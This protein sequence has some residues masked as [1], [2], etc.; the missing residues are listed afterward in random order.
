MGV[1]ISDPIVEVDHLSLAYPTR[2]GHP[3]VPILQ[4]VSVA[5][6]RGGALTLMG[7]SGSGKS[8]LLRC[9]NRLVEPTAGTVRFDGR[10]I[11]SLDPR[12]LRRR[13]ALVMQTPVLFEGTVRD[14]L[15]LRPA[16]TPG[17]FA[18]ARLGA[19]LAE[20]GLEPAVLD[21]DAA[22]L[23]GG[24][25]QRVTLA[26]A[27][28]RD[29]QVLLLDE[30]TSA[31]DPPNVT[32]VVEA[33]ARL[34]EARG[35]DAQT[36]PTHP[37]RPWGQWHDRHESG[38]PPANTHPTLHPSMALV[39]QQATGAHPRPTDVA[40]TAGLRLARGVPGVGG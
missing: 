30:P 17:D 20:V 26:R 25:K 12:E 23:S 34:R 18:D 37:S 32:R 40:G 31:L 1:D 10:D 11:R 7:P 13:A 39:S 19:G 9:L 29:P 33:I 4:D 5:V 24:E 15:R 36:G 28:L 8:T 38:V 16:D 22:T 2:R 3:A 6:E 21:R 14:N 27:L 35:L